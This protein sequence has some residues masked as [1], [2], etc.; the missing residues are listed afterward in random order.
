[1]G[2][3]EIPITK[4]EWSVKDFSVLGAPCYEDAWIDSFPFALKRY[5]DVKF[6]I[7][8]TANSKSKHVGALLM[9]ADL[10]NYAAMRIMFKIWIQGLPEPDCKLNLF[11]I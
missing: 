8:F 7:D 1:M 6:I 9:S 10:G 3:S 11:F 4:I 5:P 2:D